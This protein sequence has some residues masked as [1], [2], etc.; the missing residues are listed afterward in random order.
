[1]LIALYIMGFIYFTGVV[2]CALIGCVT[3][4]FASADKDE[5]TANGAYYAATR[6]M[7]FPIVLYKYIKSG[8]AWFE[9]EG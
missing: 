2:L 1:M 9:M 6:A 8:K 5:K 7:I 3:Y 4:V